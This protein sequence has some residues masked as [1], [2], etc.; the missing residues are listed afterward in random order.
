MIHVSWQI[1]LPVEGRCQD[2]GE[3]LSTRLRIWATREW[4]HRY[5]SEDRLRRSVDRSVAARVV[6]RHGPHCP[7][8]SRRAS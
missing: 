7:G 4:I 5:E 6:E 1:E 8:R 2:C 3:D